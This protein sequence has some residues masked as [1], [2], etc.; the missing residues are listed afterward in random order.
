MF[1]FLKKNIPV[2]V[3]TQKYFPQENQEVTCDFRKDSVPM[4]NGRRS[5]DTGKLHKYIHMYLLLMF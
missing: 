3:S 4:S 5:S 2:P 1:F